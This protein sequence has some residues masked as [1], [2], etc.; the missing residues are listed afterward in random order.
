MTLNAN[1][2]NC[3]ICTDGQEDICQRKYKILKKKKQH[4]SNKKS[5]KEKSSVCKLCAIKIKNLTYLLSLCTLH[6]F[7]LATY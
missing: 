2:M 1:E 6:N 5:G 7:N 3:N 4:G